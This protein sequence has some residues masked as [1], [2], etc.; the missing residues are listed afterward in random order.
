MKVTV[1]IP[2]YNERENITVLLSTLDKVTALIS[3]HTFSYLIVDDNSP[4]G[5]IEKVEQYQATHKNVY[6]LTGVK[7]GLGKALLRG[8]TYAMMSLKAEILVQIDADLSHD[9]NALPE[10]FDAFDRGAEFVV[11]SRYIPG[12]SIPDNWAIHRKIYSVIGN[13]IVRFGLGYLKVHDWTGGYRVF[14]KKFFE[15][16]KNDLA[17]YQGYVFQIA[18]LHASIANGAKIAEVPI[19]FTDRRYG[20]SKI[21]PSQYI[22]DVIIYILT[23]KIMQIKQSIVFKFCVV[24]S[25]GFIINTIILELF[26]TLGMHP[27]VGSLVGGE[28]AILSNFVLNNSWT[29]HMHKI[30]GGKSIAKKFIQFNGTSLGAIAIQA[31]T[32]TAGTYLLGVTSYRIF[33]IVGVAIGLVWNYTMYSRFIWKK[34]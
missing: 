11:G 12:G 34:L 13:A 23:Q 3:N 8:M 5:T 1:I 16:A 9:P 33:Y 27:T 28:L 4:D 19:H 26:V 30:T 6:L 2:T 14:R 15:L 22:R 7:E 21:A 10:F 25:I 24:G 32:V 18:F 17:K 31:G 29:F 20:H